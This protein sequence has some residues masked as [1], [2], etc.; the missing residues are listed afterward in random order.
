L[1]VPAGDSEALARALIGLLDDAGCRARMGDAGRRRVQ[2]RFG[3]ST[4]IDRLL[5]VYSEV[6]G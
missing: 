3:R 2:Q 6:S 4:M 5:E 1:L